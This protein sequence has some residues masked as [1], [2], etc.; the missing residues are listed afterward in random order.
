M[1]NPVKLAFKMVPETCP[2]VD[3]ALE[4]ASSAIKEQT[5][6]LR[7]ALINVLE[8]NQEL[9]NKVD[10]LVDEIDNLKAEI[11]ELSSQIEDLTNE[12]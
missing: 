1:S 9:Q 7:N 12:Q 11:E 8:E 5:E 10:S 4:I 2:F 6:K 3:N